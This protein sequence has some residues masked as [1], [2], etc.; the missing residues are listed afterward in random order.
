[1][2][3]DTP[4]DV[5]EQKQLLIVK[6][7]IFDRNKSVWGYRFLV[8]HVQEDGN[9]AGERSD[10][11]LVT[12]QLASI[13]AYRE[14][15]ATEIFFVLSVKDET[16]LEQTAF[17]LNLA[18]CVLSMSGEAVNLRQCSHLAD[19][20]RER[21]G[22][23]AAEADDPSD[24]LEVVLKQ[25]DVVK[26][27]MAGKNPAEIVTLCQ[28]FKGCS[29]KLMAANVENWETYEGARALGFQYFQGSFFGMPEVKA[30]KV[31]QSTSVAKLQLLKALNSP[32]CGMDELASIIASD[33]SLS[34]RILR[35]IN[36]A[37]F[38]FQTQ[39]KS[40]Q[41][42]VTLL[43]LKELKHWCTVVV[44]TDIDSTPKGE[45][46]AYTA[47]LR[48]R[49][50]SRFAELSTTVTP[51]PDSMFM[52]GLFSK[53][54]ALLSFPMEQALENVSLD[55]NLMDGLCGVPNEYNTLTRMMES[56]EAGDCSEAS[57]VLKQYAVNCVEMA[58]EYMKAATWTSQ[59]L[60]EMQQ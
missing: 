45:E 57:K 23:L 39:I 34:Y 14:S 40:I 22:L 52:L 44:M 47:L 1:M 3:R 42:A 37:S 13:F 15:G 30:A 4:E 25:C 41:Q 12:E 56:I 35:Y 18:N 59:Q 29:G 55:T 20:V 28:K 53:L 58:A 16:P 46:V 33:I 31:L 27:S 19:L 51:S 43:G 24:V 17:P 36:S 54:D 8:N 60:S 5:Q 10:L 49:F 2:M 9:I 11:E 6:Q 50:L 7:P 48:A 26:V 21:G 38:G 32:D